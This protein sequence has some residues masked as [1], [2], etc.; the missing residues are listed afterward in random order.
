MY[1]PKAG[2]LCGVTGIVTAIIDFPNG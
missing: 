2:S 1:F